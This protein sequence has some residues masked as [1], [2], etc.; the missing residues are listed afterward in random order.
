VKIQ[1]CVTNVTRTAEG[2][3]V[4]AYLELLKGEHALQ[5]DDFVPPGA[6]VWDCGGV[7]VV[8][9]RELAVRWSVKCWECCLRGIMVG[10]FQYKGYP[11]N[12]PATRAKGT[13]RQQAS[14]LRHECA[15]TGCVTRI[16]GDYVSNLL[17]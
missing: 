3:V 11:P 7:V 5:D 2:C 15:L 8:P 10:G 14:L 1:L 16:I 4:A 12:V 6:G 17:V 13:R 9:V